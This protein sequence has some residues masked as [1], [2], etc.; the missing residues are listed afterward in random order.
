MISRVLI[1]RRS[2]M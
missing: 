2:T 1:V